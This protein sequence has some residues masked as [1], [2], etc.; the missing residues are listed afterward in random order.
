MKQTPVLMFLAAT[1]AF[2]QGTGTIHGS[3][4]DPSG[5][6][7]PGAR[8]TAVLEERGTTRKVETDARGSYVLPA[9]PVGT[10]A[11]SV[12]GQGF[13]VFRQ[14]RSTDRERER[15]RGCASWSW[16]AFPSPYR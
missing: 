5:L 15:A 7:V 12:E 13:K 2:A 16:A 6:G 4:T 1:A 3:V 8:V 11:V 9:L 14:A 10:Y